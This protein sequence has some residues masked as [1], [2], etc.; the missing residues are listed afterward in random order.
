MFLHFCITLTLVTITLPAI[1][2]IENC[3]NAPYTNPVAPAV[4]IV[5]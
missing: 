3:A 2:A 5:K 1:N 4:A